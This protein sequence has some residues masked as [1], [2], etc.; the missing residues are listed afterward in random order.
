MALTNGGSTT[1]NKNVSIK[2]N[3]LGIYKNI[4]NLKVVK[5]RAI[6]QLKAERRNRDWRHKTENPIGVKN[7]LIPIKLSDSKS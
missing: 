7:N 6:Y 4:S 5:K 1:Q 3:N 2:Q